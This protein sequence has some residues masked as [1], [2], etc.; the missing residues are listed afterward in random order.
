MIN[1]HYLVEGYSR[2]ASSY[3]TNNVISQIIVDPEIEW[4]HRTIPLI[5]LKG[6]VMNPDILR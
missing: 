6:G 3:H 5:Y 1:L 4:H 2:N